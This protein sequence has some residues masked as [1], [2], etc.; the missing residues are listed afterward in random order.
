MGVNAGFDMVPRLHQGAIDRRDWES[1]V[2]AIKN[3]Y[4]DDDLVDFKPNYI[5]FKVG[6]HPLIPYEGHKFLRFSSK[7]SNGADDYIVSVFDFAKGC[8]GSRVRYWNENA[9]Q[10]GFYSWEDVR[11]SLRSYEQVCLAI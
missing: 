5:E 3:R 6:D 10:Q 8:F 1:F 4:V 9:V 7:L 2:N 11:G